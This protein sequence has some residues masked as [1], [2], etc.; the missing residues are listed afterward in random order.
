MRSRDEEFELASQ[1]TDRQTRGRSR[2]VGQA[3]GIFTGF[4]NMQH[5]V[6]QRDVQRDVAHL[7]APARTVYPSAKRQRQTPNNARE[8]GSKT[9]RRGP[10]TAVL[11]LCSS[12]A[13]AN[14]TR[15]WGEHTGSSSPATALQ[16]QSGFI[17]IRL[18][19]AVV[20]RIRIDAHRPYIYC[21]EIQML[22]ER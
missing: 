16:V 14:R 13:T 18:T 8:N 10:A 17:S 2:D 7:I 12:S 5:S 22:I 21:P 11:W 6:A 3:A 4:D 20:G 15:K 19:V 9:H 1:G